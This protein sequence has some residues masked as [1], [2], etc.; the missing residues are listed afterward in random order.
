MAQTASPS[1]AIDL[2]DIRFS[3]RGAPETL[4]VPE[5]RVGSGERL[6]LM[7]A[8]GSGKSTLLALIGGVL[9]PAAGSVELLGEDVSAHSAAQRDRFRADH[10]GFIFQLFNLLPY[11]SV[12]DNVTLPCRFSE[13]RRRRA[14]AERDT[15]EGEARRLLSHLG[16]I[17]EQ[18]LSRAVTD[19]S[20]GQ[21]Q[22]VAAARALIGGPEILIADEPTSSLDAD[23]R[24]SFIELLLAECEIT[25]STLL[26]VSHDQSLGRFFDRQ[27]SMDQIN[28]LEG[29]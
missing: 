23:A 28:K 13:R 4:H 12:L 1:S 19:L 8:S 2:E 18:T 10:I 20:I 16:L 15:L 22:R 17:E 6:F 3:Y 27:L 11:L 25:N 26:F 21:Q 14:C 24:A 29:G 7:G 9:T 5:L